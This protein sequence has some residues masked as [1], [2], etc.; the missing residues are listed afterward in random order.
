ME[1][2]PKKR[3]RDSELDQKINADLEENWKLSEWLSTF[4]PK[5]IVDTVINAAQGNTQVIIPYNASPKPY[6]P[7]QS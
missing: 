4:D 5:T 3:K 7:S 2:P 1:S 6:K